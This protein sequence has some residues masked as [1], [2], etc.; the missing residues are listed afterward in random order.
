MM[1]INYLNLHSL[2]ETTTDHYNTAKLIFN[3]KINIP[4]PLFALV[5]S[6]VDAQSQKQ[7][8]DLLRYSEIKHRRYCPFCCCPSDDENTRMISYLSNEKHLDIT[9]CH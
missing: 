9:C 3:E 7:Q 5:L 8:D 6:K 2:K 4:Y 1:C